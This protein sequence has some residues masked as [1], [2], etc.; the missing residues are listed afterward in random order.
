MIRAEKDFRSMA[1]PMLLAGAPS[2][3]D[4]ALSQLCH[5]VH[6]VAYSTAP[7]ATGRITESMVWDAQR[8]VYVIHGPILA[9]MLG[10]PGVATIPTDPSQA[11][12]AIYQIAVRSEPSRAIDRFCQYHFQDHADCNAHGVITYTQSYTGCD[13][14]TLTHSIQITPDVAGSL[15]L[16]EIRFVD[17]QGVPSDPLFL[18]AHSDL[19]LRVR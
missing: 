15:P 19:R 7:P 13:L 5:D 1:M 6:F 16:L 3:A 12:R 10:N 18:S 14:Q 9:Q 17:V 11:A 8:R 2:A 4:V